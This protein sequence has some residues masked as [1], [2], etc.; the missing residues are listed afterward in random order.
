VERIEQETRRRLGD[1][2]FTQ[3]S[4]EGRKASWREHVEVTLAS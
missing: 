1:V 3:A 4:D 2:K